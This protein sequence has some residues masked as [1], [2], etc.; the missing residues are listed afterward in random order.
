MQHCIFLSTC[1]SDVQVLHM[2]SG[3]DTVPRVVIH[4]VD[5]GMQRLK[6]TTLKLREL[7][8]V[9]Y[10]MTPSF[11]FDAHAMSYSFLHWQ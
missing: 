4:C 1:G 2:T 10:L 9:Q 5:D 3:I 6:R 11:T 7:I 8:G